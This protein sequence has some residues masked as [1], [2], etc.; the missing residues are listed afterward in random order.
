MESTT[1][2]DKWEF[3]EIYRRKRCQMSDFDK[4]TKA[5]EPQPSYE[6]GLLEA[7]EASEKE[8]TATRYCY[9]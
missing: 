4:S 9:R 3:R 6:I 7:S 5:R 2:Y 1:R 8:K